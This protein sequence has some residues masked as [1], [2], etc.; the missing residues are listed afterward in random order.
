MSNEIVKY[1]SQFNQVRLKGFNKKE[2]DYLLAMMWLAKD[3][4]S[5]KIT[6]TFEQV[7]EIIGDKKK[8]WNRITDFLTNA[9]KKLI[10]SNNRIETE[11]YIEYFTL[12]DF[13][14]IDKEKHITTISTA[15][16]FQFV[17]NELLKFTRFELSEFVSLNSKYS[18]NLYRNLKQWRNTGFWQVEI[19]ELKIRLDVPRAYNFAQVK[20]KILT[21]AIKELND[22]QIFKNL[23]TELLR[24]KRGVRGGGTS[25]YEKINFIFEPEK[26]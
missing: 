6:F 8:N 22:K 5:Q 17:L 10:K 24:S 25:K 3:K 11:R 13:F 2:L 19:N 12:F 23:H 16:Y 4:Q 21:P 14:R 26:K 7:A 18:K 1:D 20:E 9:Y 15:T